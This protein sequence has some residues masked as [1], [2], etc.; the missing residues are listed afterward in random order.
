[1]VGGLNRGAADASVV[2][3]GTLRGARRGTI[4]AAAAMNGAWLNDDVVDL[5]DCDDG[6]ALD[7]VV[8]RD[9]EI[10][11][12]RDSRGQ[13]LL[14]LASARN[15]VA[16]IDVLL[17]HGADVHA[18]DR[19]SRWTPL[20][21]AVY[22]GALL[23]AQRLLKHKGQQHGPVD[24]EGNSPFDLIEWRYSRRN[25]SGAS[26]HVISSFG[27]STNFQLGTVSDASVQARAKPIDAL[28]N[29][30]IVAFDL[31][32]IGGAAIS[33]SGTVYTWGI[34][35]AGRLGLG[36]DVTRIRPEPVGGLSSRGR[37]VS[38]A[39]CL[40]HAVFLMDSGDV[41]TCGKGFLGHEGAGRSQ[42][43]QQSDVP[44][45]VEKGLRRT[46]IVSIS[47]SKFRT[48]LV[49]D[50]GEAFLLGHHM[51]DEGTDYY[52]TRIESLVGL[53]V[54]RMLTTNG[55]WLVQTSDG[56][57][58]EQT[59]R[60][61]RFYRV[62][63]SRGYRGSGRR[64]T[65]V[66]VSTCKTHS[67][68]VISDGTLWVWPSRAVK[69]SCIDSSS[70]P[71][72]P[73]PV[74][75]VR[76]VFV[77]RAS[78]AV[79]HTA[80]ITVHGDL[81][82]W[83]HDNPQTASSP[84]HYAAA[85]GYR[86]SK[87]ERM[88]KPRPLVDV[89]CAPGCT[90]VSQEFVLPPLPNLPASETPS[91]VPSLFKLCERFLC[92]QGI[93]ERRVLPALRF[94]H[95][96]GTTDLADYCAAFIVENAESMLVSALRDLTPYE[97]AFLERVYRER[98]VAPAVLCYCNHAVPR[99]QDA[100]DDELELEWFIPRHPKHLKAKIRS[101]S[102]KLS[103]IAILSERKA[104]GE[105]LNKEQC[106]KLKLRDALR[107]YLQQC[108]GAL[109]SLPEELLLADIDSDN[110]PVQP[111][112]VVADLPVPV[113]NNELSIVGADPVAGAEAAVPKPTPRA[114]T[115]KGPRLP[116]GWSVPDSEPGRSPSPVPVH[117]V[118]PQWATVRRSRSKSRTS[119]QIGSPLLSS[120]IGSSPPLPTISSPTGQHSRGQAAAN[121]SQP[122]RLV[123]AAVTGSPLK[124]PAPGVSTP[125]IV[126]PM[127]PPMVVMSPPSTQPRSVSKAMTSRQ[128]PAVPSSSP[129]V[130]LVDYMATVSKS[131]S[132][133]T[134]GSQSSPFPVRPRPNM[135]SRPSPDNNL[136]ASPWGQRPASAV[137][138]LAEI[139]SEALT[140]TQAKTPA[141]RSPWATMSA[142][143]RVPT[144][145]VPCP[146][147][148]VHSLASIMSEEQSRGAQVTGSAPGS[149]PPTCWGPRANQRPKPTPMGFIQNLQFIEAEFD[150]TQL[151]AQ[152]QIEQDVQHRKQQQQQQ[153]QSGNSGRRRSPRICAG[154]D[155]NARRSG[156]SAVARSTRPRC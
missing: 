1:M 110:V 98:V 94:A 56:L 139:Q 120:Q 59:R 50:N 126:S 39:V 83:E 140:E 146:P 75:T 66:D 88:S 13:T 107:V 41:F 92:K 8:A 12:A 80:V 43:Q 95:N 122:V 154:D 64:S 40:T 96:V 144:P 9:P 86:V 137:K 155:R 46:T 129:S 79:D 63:I 32:E 14:H 116:A 51:G 33:K 90:A 152:V 29:E 91:R 145:Q 138:S 78:T 11:T 133:R 54:A 106:D 121:A 49:A 125:A 18:V 111:E 135:Q 19:E 3:V 97:V 117:Y 67:V 141:K 105:L 156:R 48:C 114:A 15:A 53:N 89:R 7:R 109:A 104:R 30:D 136:P 28:L 73:R 17:T 113:D 21:A 22:R 25:T 128:H 85:L 34:N 108:Q 61:A 2:V 23:A 112:P 58:F 6:A 82:D 151:D 37:C 130:C 70:R 84:Q 36:D 123:N 147:G 5:V 47:C 115:K 150:R 60:E 65:V 132:S 4:P 131:K 124:Q 24:Y 57:L 119:D 101:L 148:R 69:G 35:R 102:K 81:I 52:P 99:S 100:N 27:S 134:P 72:A 143:Q 20:H 31:C 74:R 103:Q 45:R 62:P 71:I 26:R 68:A 77:V 127:P 55:H 93:D 118:E 76:D 16:C 153:P 87:P 10:L 149:S 42:G 142:Q 38:V 44:R